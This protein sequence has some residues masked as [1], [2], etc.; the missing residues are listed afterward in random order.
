MYVFLIQTKKIILEINLQRKLAKYLLKR[1]INMIKI[2]WNF[3]VLKSWH[4]QQKTTI[5]SI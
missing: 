1:N 3:E 2:H 4:I 5:E